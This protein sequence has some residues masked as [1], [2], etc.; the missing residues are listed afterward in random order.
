MASRKV[1]HS[2]HL[3]NS[4][5]TFSNAFHFPFSSSELRIFFLLFFHYFYCISSS[6]MYPVVSYFVA[7]Y[8]P[9]Y[10]CVRFFPLLFRAFW[11]ATSK[12]IIIWQC[13]RIVRFFRDQIQR[14][15]RRRNGQK[16]CSTNLWLEVSCTTWPIYL[17]Q[18]LQNQNPKEITKCSRHLNLFRFFFFLVRF[19]QFET[20][21]V[22]ILFV[23]FFFFVF[24]GATSAPLPRCKV[25]IFVGSLADEQGTRH[26]ARMTTNAESNRKCKRREVDS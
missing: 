26:V 4:H 20:N 22:G 2:K 12:I 8:F 3:K 5:F 17:P 10:L 21:G 24:F 6:L 13:S 1:H 18:V 11:R 25:N 7:F 15:E 9:F 23:F 19:H 14:N 16:I